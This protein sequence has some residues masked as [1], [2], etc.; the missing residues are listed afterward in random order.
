MRDLSHLFQPIGIRGMELK[1]RVVMAPMVT[2][3][4]T[5]EGAVTQRLVDYLVARAWGGVGLI[6][7]EAAYVRPDG[8]GFRSELGIYKDELIPGLQELT[9]LVHEGKAKIA[10]QIFHAGRQTSAATTGVQPVAPSPLADPSSGELPREL[11][12]SEIQTL[13]DAFVQAARRAKQAGFDA[14]EIHGAHGYLIGEFLSPFSN[15]RTDEYGGNPQGWSRFAVE[16]VQKVR[17]MVGPDYP[18]IFRLSADEFVPG[19][20]TLT[21]TKSIARYVQDAGADVISV[22]VG[23]Y[24]S[25][26]MLIVPPMTLNSCGS[27]SRLVRRMKAPTRVILGSPSNAS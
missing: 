15:R 3:Y 16:I 7:T 9:R 12:I 10:M 2:K 11:S 19:G 1:N 4:A 27:S 25:P 26:G 14:V 6:E 24:A 20:L 5:E 21:E 8:K 13:E 17:Q 18:I 23:N 22:S